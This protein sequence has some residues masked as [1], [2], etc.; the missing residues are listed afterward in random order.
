MATTQA[1]IAALVITLD[2]LF[3]LSSHRVFF[4]VQTMGNAWIAAFRSLK[5]RM[6]VS[7]LGMAMCKSEQKPVNKVNFGRFVMPQCSGCHRLERKV[8][9]FVSQILGDQMLHQGSNGVRHCTQVF[10]GKLE[11]PNCPIFINFLHPQLGTFE[12]RFD[13]SEWQH[14][15]S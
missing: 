7:P 5:F 4:E 9:L 8:E 10:N 3:I 1:S 2:V 12:V 13:G 11:R 6:G 15:D 14:C